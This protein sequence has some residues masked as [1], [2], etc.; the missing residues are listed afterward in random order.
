MIQLRRKKILD[1]IE[2]KGEV[3]FEELEA[4]VPDVSLMTIRRDLIALENEGKIIRIRGGAKS[5]GFEAALKE[6]AFSQRLVS[7]EAAKNKIAKKALEFVASGRS[8]YIDAGTTC[9]AFAKQLPDDNLF[10]IT[11]SPHTAL[12]LVCKRNVRVNLTGGQLNSDNLTLSGTNAASYL[13]GINIDIAFMSA[14]AFSLQNGLSC[15]D[16]YEAEL[17]RLII[18]KARLVV[19]LMDMSKIGASMPY[20]FAQLSQINVI[21]TDGIFPDNYLRAIRR[22]QVRVV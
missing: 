16:F 9:L 12:E 22:A 18:R 19:V 10:V 7:H 1:E 3:E 4:L 2:R 11:S 17:K 6:A 20:T 14:S 13:K 15:G 8:L 21:V 5:R